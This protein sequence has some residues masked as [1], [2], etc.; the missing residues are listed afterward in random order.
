MQAIQD[1]RLN[2]LIDAERARQENTI[3]LIAS[4]NYAPQEILAVTGSV[5]TNK[6]AEGTPGKRFYGGCSVI[7]EI[8]QLAIDRCKSL[9]GAAHANVQPHA[10]SQANMAVYMAFLK[11]GDTIMG[12]DLAAGGH[13][14][15]G[16]QAN[17]SGT[18]YKKISYTVDPT[19]E[20][21][22][23]NKLEAC[24]REH[25]PKLIIGG[26]SAYPRAINFAAMAVIAKAVGA[27]FMAD[28]AHI[29]G[30]VAT[31]LH[32]NPT[33]Y[34]DCV[35]GTTHKTL[36]GP[37]GG[38]ILAQENYATMIDKAVMPGIQGGPLMH[39]I[40]AK[41]L[42]FGNA[43]EPSFVS[44]QQQICANA[45]AMAQAFIERGYRLIAGGTDTHMLILDLRAHNL[46]GKEA[47]TLLDQV[48]LLV[49]RS[50]I[51]FDT[52][53]PW[54]GSGIRLGTSAMT[55][56]GMGE[57]EARLIAEYIDMVLRNPASCTVIDTVSDAVRTLARDFPVYTSS[58]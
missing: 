42:C 40:A 24:A 31:G 32:A 38:F 20:L 52:Q 16:Y 10:G 7:D 29:A 54:L 55:T 47:E 1:T 6:Y 2:S 48:G 49:S 44:Y 45:R 12:M 17:F 37:R 26:A 35:T 13:L 57:Q 36:R 18:L 43:S 27:F 58:Q 19:T 50:C 4:E 56:R 15:H 41:A 23:Y 11:P 22:D 14:T 30:L 8:E 53:S 28:I 33:S 34:A 51:P 3:S 25:K 21:L 5:L 46:T 9:F 39:V